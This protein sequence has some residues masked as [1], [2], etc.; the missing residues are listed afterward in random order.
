MAHLKNLTSQQL[1]MAASG[2][3]LVAGAMLAR[4]NNL[5][6]APLAIAIVC[7]LG[8]LAKFKHR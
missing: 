1:A 4:G 2:A 7:G 3:G 5:G 8:A 6:F